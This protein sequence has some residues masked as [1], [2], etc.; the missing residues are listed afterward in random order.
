MAIQLQRPGAVSIHEMPG[1]TRSGFFWL[2]L[3]P[4]ELRCH[5]F[6]IQMTPAGF[7]PATKS[8]E[9]SGSF[10]TGH[11][12]IKR[13][14]NR[15]RW[16]TFYRSSREP[17]HPLIRP[18]QGNWFLFQ[19]SQLPGL[20]ISRKDYINWIYDPSDSGTIGRNHAQG[21]LRK[22]HSI[23][24][25][26]QHGINLPRSRSI[27]CR[28]SPC[29]SQSHLFIRHRAYSIALVTLPNPLEVFWESQGRFNFN[30]NALSPT[31]N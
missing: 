10:N 11:R 6:E 18:A 22:C 14:N 20:S 8:S 17:H 26:T 24:F 4:V 12:M 5:F 28:L 31:W 2:L 30:I 16:V 15:S 23:W 25:M 27:Y 3:Y 19:R 21:R 9:V 1:N 29:W 7:E 13:G